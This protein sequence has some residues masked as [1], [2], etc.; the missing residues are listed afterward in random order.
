M[1]DLVESLSEKAWIITFISSFLPKSKIYKRGKTMNNI[2]L[3][4]HQLRCT[5][6]ERVFNV[7]DTVPVLAIATS[8]GRTVMGLVQAVVGLLFA[9][10]S[11]CGAA[12]ARRIGDSESQRKWDVL[13]GLGLGEA[14]AGSLLA[15]R[16][17]AETILAV[18][19]LSIGTILIW[20]NV[21]EE[22][23]KAQ[24]GISTKGLVEGINERFG[25]NLS[26]KVPALPLFTLVAAMHADKFI[27]ARSESFSAL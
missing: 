20:K 8:P 1:A 27:K 13:T 17:L 7:M 25:L 16:G 22:D 18:T 4:A 6:V 9:A 21:I 2:E 10:V 14:I 24:E 11:A 23:L 5:N 19:T 26:D 3:N 15:V 12:H